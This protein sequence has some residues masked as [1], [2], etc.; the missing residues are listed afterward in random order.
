MSTH[1]HVVVSVVYSGIELLDVV[2]PL[3]VFNA[4]NR[5]TG[6]D[7]YTVAITSPNGDPIRSA[8]GAWLGADTDFRHAPRRI[9]TL[10]VGG[11]YPD[12][13]GSP[14]ITRA[15]AEL[16][17]RAAR[18]ASVCTGA[19][20]LAEIGL[21]DGRRATTHWAVCDRLA[22]DFPNVDVVPDRIFVRDGPVLTSAGV[23]AGID[24]ALAIVEEDH[25][26]ALARAV[27]RWLV[28]F[29]QRPG[30]QSQFSRRSRVDVSP[31]SPIRTAVD[32]ITADPGADHR[33]PVL[34]GRVGM[35]VRN[36]A[37][38]FKATTGTTPARFVEETRVE[39]AQA[40]LETTNANLRAIARSV[41]FG[42][43][44]TMRQAFK[45]QLGINPSEYRERFRSTDSTATPR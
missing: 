24:L 31:Q 18:V 25:G 33:V 38:T 36:F 13:P 7:L 17:A 11:S 37:R 28:V 14:A 8:S 15:L 20:L 4:A 44:E 6:R 26:S 39:A 27:G 5:I 42:H 43:A 41:G 9:G 40:L 12:P 19:L 16:A 29:L 32:A 1:P 21:L 10:L 2:G 35:S 45:R 22:Q 34:A 30:G 23:T 3:E